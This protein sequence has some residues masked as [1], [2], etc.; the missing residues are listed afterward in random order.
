MIYASS[1]KRQTSIIIDGYSKAKTENGAIAD[2]GRYI[3]KHFDKSEGENL[4]QFK[5][6]CLIDAKDSNG[7]YFLEVEEVGCASQYNEETDEM[8]YKEANFYVV[9]RIIK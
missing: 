2:M 4:Q 1:I 9:C 3:A 6:E 8:E 5:S 7:G